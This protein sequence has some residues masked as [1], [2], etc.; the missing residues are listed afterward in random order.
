MGKKKEEI[1]RLTEMVENLTSRL[2]HL[3]CEVNEINQDILE[4]EKIMMKLHELC[5]E[6]D[7]CLVYDPLSTRVQAK[8]DAARLVRLILEN[9]KKDN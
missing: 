5:D 8:A 7:K 4:K 3:S 1:K 9:T 2:S 6:W